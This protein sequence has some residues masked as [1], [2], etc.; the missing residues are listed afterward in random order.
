MNTIIPY[1]TVFTPT[2][3]RAYALHG[4]YESLLNQTYNDFEWIIVD[5]GSTDETHKLVESWINDDIL[6]IKY[7]K[8]ENQGKHVAHNLGVDNASGYLFLI[9]DSDDQCIPEALEMFK[10]Y[11]EDIPVKKRPM[12]STLTF[13]CMDKN[14]K[15]I[16]RQFPKMVNDVQDFNEQQSMRS[17]GDKWGVNVTTLMKEYKFPTFDGE[18]FIPEGIVWNRLSVKYSA[19]FVN[20][21]IKIVEYLND[22]LTSNSS[23]I[24]LNSPHGA[25]LAYK[26]QLDLKTSVFKKYKNAINYIRFSIHGNLLKDLFNSVLKKPWL[27]LFLPAG[28][29]LSALDKARI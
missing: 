7:F 19:R 18:K 6:T 11:W 24:R 8:Q 4:V 29:F 23:N 17:N 5:D 12:F 15:V 28:M 20:K 16:G 25:T 21:P 2:F 22:G 3:N 1:F 10:Y 9:F 27:I 13:L 14:N 26:E